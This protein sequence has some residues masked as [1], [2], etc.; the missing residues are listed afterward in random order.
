MALYST[1]SLTQ[2]WN[3]AATTYRS[4]ITGKYGYGAIDCGTGSNY[5]SWLQV[6][7]TGSNYVK[8]K[9]DSAATSGSYKLISNYWT[10]ATSVTYTPSEI[11]YTTSATELSAGV[12]RDWA[13]YGNAC[14]IQ[15]VPWVSYIYNT[16]PAE[17]KR[18]RLRNN[19]VIAV[20]S[21][22]TPLGN[23]SGPELVALETL[24]EMISESDFRKYL[25]YGFVLVE[26]AS[27]KIYQVYRSRA[28]TKVWENGKIVE[29]ICVRISD[30]NIP[31]TDNVIAFISMILASEDEFKKLGNVYNMREAA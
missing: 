10:D 22:A 12:L 5:T 18:E 21:R 15:Y 11:E 25:K 27:G 3:E 4:D 14:N 8:Y 26:G 16:N 29:E 19:L 28:H 20:K 17:T 24:R 1:S 31:L 7:A 9:V 23:A 6:G 2:L 13:T 30:H